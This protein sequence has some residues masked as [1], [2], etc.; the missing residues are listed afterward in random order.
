MTGSGQILTASATK[1]SDLFWGIRGAGVNFGIVTSATYRIYDALNSGMV[2]NADLIFDAEKNGTI[3]QILS[4]YQGNQDDKLAISIASSLRNNIVSCCRL[5]KLA[6]FTNN[7]P[8]LRSMSVP[9]TMA[10]R[11]RVMLPSSLSSTRSQE[12]ATFL[13]FH[14][15]DWCT[16][17]TSAPIHSPVRK[18]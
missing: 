3:F 7:A 14:T 15:T 10:L 8:S 2:Y 4:T 12:S 17:P 18:V 5:S 1:N 13:R 11:N 16:L 6:V 9:S